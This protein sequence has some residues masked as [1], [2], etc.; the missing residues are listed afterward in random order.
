MINLIPNTQKK[1]MRKGFYFRL[2]VLF[3]VMAGVS[4]II[5]FVAILPAYFLSSVKSNLIDSKLEAQ[6]QEVVPLP[7]QET[8]A[9]IKDLDSKLGIIERAERSN[10]VVSGRVINAVIAKKMQEIKITDIAYEK[11][12]KNDPTL[13][14]TISIQGTAP[15]RE[16][17]LLFRQALEDDT[18]F[19]SVDLPISNFVKGSNIQFYLSLIP[20]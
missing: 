2:L 8:L 3:L 19:K 10:F 13:G 9:V 12:S 7:D 16:M 20:S 5:A 1:E 18:T 15:S 11:N 6:G 4:I 14:P 17:L